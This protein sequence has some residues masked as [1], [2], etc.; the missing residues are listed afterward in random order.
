MPGFTLDMMKWLSANGLL[1]S[2]MLPQCTADLDDQLPDDELKSIVRIGDPGLPS[3]SAASRQPRGNNRQQLQ[4]I[5]MAK[6]R[7]FDA[8]PDQSEVHMTRIFV[9]TPLAG[10]VPV[11]VDLGWTG[12]LC[13]RTLQSVAGVV[14]G[15]DLSPESLRFRGKVLSSNQSLR[16]SGI[17][18]GSVLHLLGPNTK[19][20]ARRAMS[21]RERIMS[22][23]VERI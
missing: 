12:A 22:R 11:D 17:E 19:P 5:S 20:A 13:L 1:C 8:K 4:K 10:M 14:G 21:V 23:L 3:L 7:G 6:S 18:L 16:E 9:K 2:E 15:C